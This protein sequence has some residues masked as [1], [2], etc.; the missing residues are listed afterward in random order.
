MRRLMLSTMI[1]VAAALTTPPVHA[2][3]IPTIRPARSAMTLAATTVDSQEFHL[4]NIRINGQ[5]IGQPVAPG[6]AV[7][8]DFNWS[9]SGVSGCPD[10][11]Q[12]LYVGFQG[13]SAT[14]VD[15]LDQ[16]PDSGSFSGSLTAPAKA[17][18]YLIMFNRTL[19]LTC[20]PITSGGGGLS[21]IVATVVTLKVK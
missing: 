1:A 7:Q 15:N 10:C 19:Q 5:T 13:T 4:S 20:I 6:S 17:G 16:G 14:C 8:I 11:R 12:Q 3:K 21:S 18:T 9:T 2:A